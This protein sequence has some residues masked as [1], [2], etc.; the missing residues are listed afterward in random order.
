MDNLPND[1]SN[2]NPDSIGANNNNPTPALP[3]GGPPPFGSNFNPHVNPPDPNNPYASQPP[4]PLNPLNTP[5]LPDSF[6]PHPTHSDV[7]QHRQRDAHGHF[8]P[9]H[10]VNHQP[11]TPPNPQQP[12]P[13]PNPSAPS[14]PS[15]PSLVPPLIETNPKEDSKDED[16][17]LIKITNPVTYL[18]RWWNRILAKEGIDFKLG[19]KIKP[20]TAVLIASIVITGG[21]SSGITALVFKAFWPTSSPILHRQ[22]IQSGTIQTG[23]GGFYLASSDQTIWKL[24]PKKQNIN[25]NDQVGKQVTVTGNMTKEPNLIEVSEII[26]SD[27][28]QTSLPPQVTQNSLN[29]P[30]TP[31]NPPNIPNQD[32]LP[33]L[34]SGLQWDLTQR[35]ILLFTSGKRRIEQEGVYMESA[36]VT[37]L[38]QEFIN[39]YTNQLITAGFKE[40]LNATDPN[41]TTITYAKDDL[42]LTFGIKNI[43]SGSGETKRLIGYKAFIEH[44]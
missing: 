40:T 35:K 12:Q 33:K 19:F 23:T 26:L 36:Q 29:S 11:Q 30:N 6:P 24:K 4:S 37:E 21:L 34:Y 32:L 43:Y 15:D 38:P 3:T 2:P 44:N 25:L 5:N 7:A 39:Y 27:S 9:E 8:L 17:P 41:G 42:F 28:S 16:P 13:V 31:T 18:K 14:N 20:I 22:I 1:P 10:S